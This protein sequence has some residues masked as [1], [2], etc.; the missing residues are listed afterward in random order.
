MFTKNDL[1]SMTDYFDFL[2]TDEETFF[3]IMSKNTTHCWKIVK[4]A[5]GYQLLHAHKLSDGYHIHGQYRAMLD[6]VLDIVEHDEW[7]LGIWRH[8]N[9]GRRKQ[10]YT[11]FDQ[12]VDTYVK[13]PSYA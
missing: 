5:W 3:E 13:V 2:S 4:E 9:I 1:L 10:P 12:L 7:K 6:C 11:Y 8:K